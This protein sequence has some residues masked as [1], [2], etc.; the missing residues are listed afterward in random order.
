[1]NTQI[2]E[3]GMT[4]TA[5]AQEQTPEPTP[6]E[7][8]KKSMAEQEGGAQ[9]EKKPADTQP[10]KTEPEKK[11]EA[12]SEKKSPLDE[13]V[14]EQKKDEPEAEVDPLAEFADEKSRNWKRAR[15]VMRSQ[16]DIIK[17]KG[18]TEAEWK[19]K[20][21]EFEKQ[22]AEKPKVDPAAEEELKSLRKQIED[23]KEAFKA[24]NVELDPEFRKEFV[25]GRK[26]LVDRAAAKLRAYGGNADALVEALKMP[27][28]RARDTAIKEAFGDTVN[29]DSIASGKILSIIGDVEKLDERRADELRNAGPKFDEL[30]KRRETAAAEAAKK[31]GEYRTA[32]FDKVSKSIAETTPLLRTIEGNDEWN[33]PIIEAHTKA[34]ALFAADAKPEEV[35]SAAIKGSYFD[36]VQKLALEQHSQIKAL[37]TQLKEFEGAEPSV[38]GTGKTKKV[39]PAEEDPGKIY[40]RKMAELSGGDD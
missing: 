3:Q 6:A 34:K 40:E 28:G 18:K 38:K 2:I 29:E 36:A 25:D 30:M 23:S 39:D 5:P 21:A 8:F 13:I 14:G 12:A 11:E 4:D 17:E 27:E 16:S 10:E 7:I 35:V 31:D 26:A 24:V 22:L 33:N 32:V 20:L 9:D 15:E 19:T 37:K 1:M